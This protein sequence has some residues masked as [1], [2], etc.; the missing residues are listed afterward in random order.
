MRGHLAG[1]TA[2]AFDSEGALLSSA[3]ADR[4]VG[5]WEVHSG[6][7]IADFVGHEGRIRDVGFSPD[8]KL[9]VSASLGGMVKLWDADNGDGRAVLPPVHTIGSI[10]FGPDSNQL[11]VDSLGEGMLQLELPTG[12]KLATFHARVSGMGVLDWSADGRWIAVDSCNDRGS[13]GRLI[14]LWDVAAREQTAILRGHERS[15]QSI[16]F[17]SDATQLVSGGADET[18]RIWDIPSG[19]EQTVISEEDSVVSVAFS[20]DGDLVVSG[21]SSGSVTIWHAGNGE[22]FRR[23]GTHDGG[24][25]SVA[26]SPDGSLIA[27]GGDFD[28]PV[29]NLWDAATGALR[30]RLLSHDSAVDALAFS[31]TGSRLV[32]ASIG[33]TLIVW[34]AVTG[35]SLLTLAG[36]VG[37]LTS[38]AFSPDGNRIAALGRDGIELWDSRPAS[39]VLRGYSV[40]EFAPEDPRATFETE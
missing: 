16:K 40:R 8:G 4:S 33:G 12:R 18:I 31:P 26:F 7:R 29:V 17:N 22:I 5:L 2:L 6:R 34:D 25:V 35:E 30:A 24:V 28:N 10:A 37:P 1:I 14:T 13:R 32:S 36:R 3:S 27:S 38:V 19:N 15:I 39:V 11:A 9:L 23:L 20:P 21:T